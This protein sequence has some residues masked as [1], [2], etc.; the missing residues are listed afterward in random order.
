M[1][2]GFERLEPTTF[3]HV[4]HTLRWHHH[5]R[6]RAMKVAKQAIA[7]KQRHTQSCLE[8]FRKFG[9]KSGGEW[10]THLQ[11]MLS[12]RPTQGPFSGNMNSVSLQCIK[13]C[14]Q[15]LVGTYRQVDTRITWAAP[16][17]EKPG[18]HHRHIHTQRP[19]RLYQLVQSGNHPIDLW[20]PGIGDERQLH[21]ATATRSANRFDGKALAPHR[22]ISRRPSAC[23][24]S[25]VRLSTQSP[26]LQ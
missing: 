8:N 10:P 7:Q 26:S 5:A 21:A 13:H 11:A 3:Q 22:I 23:S 18:V 24:T 14:S 20:V 25:A 15:L 6:R 16:V 4:E 2:P 1:C 12:G 9:M 19:K 17:F